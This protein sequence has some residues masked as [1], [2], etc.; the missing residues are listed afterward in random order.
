MYVKAIDLLSAMHCAIFIFTFRLDFVIGARKPLK[1][2]ACTD[3]FTS[4]L[5]VVWQAIKFTDKLAIYICGQTR[6]KK[7]IWRKR[8]T[9]WHWQCWPV[10]SMYSYVVW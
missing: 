9:Q 8:E 7:E 5:T 1:W 4:L 3:H 2:Q 6:G 10:S